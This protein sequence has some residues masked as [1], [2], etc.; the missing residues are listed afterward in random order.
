MLAAAKGGDLKE[1]ALHFE[2][3]LIYQNKLCCGTGLA[4]PQCGDLPCPGYWD[5]DAHDWLVF[6]AIVG[7]LLIGFLLLVFTWVGNS[8]LTAAARALRLSRRLRAAVSNLWAE[9][10][11]RTDH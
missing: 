5:L 9:I 4:A 11:R 6:G 2:R 7:A 8:S 3:I 10:E 1:V